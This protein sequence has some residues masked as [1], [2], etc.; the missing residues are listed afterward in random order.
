VDTELSIKY[1]NA[2]TLESRLI[3]TSLEKSFNE[4]TMPI[5]VDCETKSMSEAGLAVQPSM[6]A[7]IFGDTKFIYPYETSV[8]L[9]SKLTVTGLKTLLDPEA[10]TAPWVREAPEALKAHKVQK[11]QNTLKAPKDSVSYP[12]PSFISGQPE[13]TA[14]ERGILLHHVMQHIDFNMC[15]QEYSKESVA[16]ELIRLNCSG[17]ITDEQLDEVDVEKIAKFISSALGGRMISSEMPVREFKFS[18]LRPAEDYFP[19]GGTDKILLQGVID[20]YFEEDGEIVVIDFKTDRV[21]EKTIAKIA[22]QYSQQLNTYADALHHI[23]G[24]HVKEKIIYFFSID[25]AYSI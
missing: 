23:T 19:G 25:R 22:Q 14:T 13:L 9:P 7:D 21:T 18:I 10:E 16:K 4:T 5:T 15:S 12:S 6:D 24:K 8:D 3:T 11:V 17:L 1:L 20:C 2:D